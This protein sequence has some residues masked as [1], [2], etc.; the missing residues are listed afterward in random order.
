MILSLTLKSTFNYNLFPK[1]KVMFNLHVIYDNNGK[2]YFIYIQCVMYNIDINLFKIMIYS[3][4]K[5]AEE[6]VY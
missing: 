4:C 1:Q 3:F 2:L 5:V 6:V